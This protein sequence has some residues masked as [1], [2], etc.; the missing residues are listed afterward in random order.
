MR[1][2]QRIVHIGDLLAQ[3]DPGPYQSVEDQAKAKKLQDQAQLDN[4]KV[5]LDRDLKLTNIVTEHPK[6]Q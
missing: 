5:D 3:I 2:R 4:A 6:K 1:P